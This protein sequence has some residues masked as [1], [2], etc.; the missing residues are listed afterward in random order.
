VVGREL[1]CVGEI[2]CM[3]CKHVVRD[4]KTK[5]SRGRLGKERKF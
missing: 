2:M 5:N 1:R 4:K 3:G